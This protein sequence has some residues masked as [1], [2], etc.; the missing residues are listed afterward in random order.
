MDSICCIVKFG[1]SKRFFHAGIYVAFSLYTQYTY[2]T[3]RSQLRS[4]LCSE[5]YFGVTHVALSGLL[6]RTVASVQFCIDMQRTA[7]FV[8]EVNFI[9][10]L[11]LKY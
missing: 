10:F 4:C 7:L 3:T 9:N 8:F 1:G 5:F 6:D 2:P 11:L